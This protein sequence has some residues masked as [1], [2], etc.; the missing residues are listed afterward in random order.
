MA[1][2]YKCGAEMSE[3]DKFCPECGT[4]VVELGEKK[5]ETAPVNKKVF[6]IGAAALIVIVAIVVLVSV[7]K[8]SGSGFDSPEEAFEAWMNG[9]MQHDFDLRLRA[10]PDFEIKHDGGETEVKKLLQEGYEQQIAKYEES[11]NTAIYDAVGS[12]TLDKDEAE[13]VIQHINNEFDVDA[14][15]SEVAVV[16][17][18]LTVRTKSGMET[19]PH[20]DSSGYA[21]KYKGKWYFINYGPVD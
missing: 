11:G 12:Y 9:Y 4:A 7:L 10:E 6:A 1:Y 19:D 3:E 15:I 18:K 13:A 2:C 14:K 8:G 17:Y 21:I 16:D 20:Y 5:R